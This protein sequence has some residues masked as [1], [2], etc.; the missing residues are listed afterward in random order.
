VSGVIHRAEP[1]GDDWDAVLAELTRAFEVTRAAAQAGDPVVYVVDNDDLLGRR[2]PGRAM[3]ATGLLSAARTAALEGAKSG[4][5]VNV[6]ALGEGADPA[7]VDEWAGHFLRSPGI[8]G[9]LLHV[10]PGHLGKALP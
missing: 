10:G 3:V 5:T 9:E 7:L 2:G 6:I 1:V 4:W 8:T